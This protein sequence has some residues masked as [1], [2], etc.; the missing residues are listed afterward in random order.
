[1]SLSTH[2][3]F[4]RPTTHSTK[5]RDNVK[6]REELVGKGPTFEKGD[7]VKIRYQV[8][9]GNGDYMFSTG[10]GREFQDDVGGEGGGQG[11]GGTGVVWAR[12]IASV[13]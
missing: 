11:T 12:E 6:Y 10:Y 9:K 13:G 1:M 8:Y 2:H 4:P 3:A 5:V 7:L